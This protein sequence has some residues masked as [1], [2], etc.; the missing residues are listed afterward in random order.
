MM[1]GMGGMGG[2][3]GGMGGG[4]DPMQMMG[5]AAMA[6]QLAKQVKDLSDLGQKVT[7]RCLQGESKLTMQTALKHAE[8]PAWMQKSMI[9][10][11]PAAL[12]QMADAVTA[13]HE[14]NTLQFGQSTG[15][16]LRTVLLNEGGSVLPEK[17]PPKETYPNVT[18][19]FMQ[20]FFGKGMTATIKT[21]EAPNGMQIDLHKCVGRNVGLFESIWASVV[22]F[23]DNSN[24]PSTE[25]DKEQ[26]AT[27]MAYF[28]MQMPHIMQQCDL[29]PE[30][31]Q[32]LKD[33]A[34][35]M[36][37]GVSMQMHIPAPAQ[38]ETN[39]K[40]VTDMAQTVS[41]YQK[42]IQHP[43]SSLEFGQNLGKV[44]QSALETSMSQKYYV[45][46]EGNLRLRQ[47]TTRVPG[48]GSMLTP[49]LLVLVVVLLL[50]VVVAVKS[51][52]AL[53]GWKEHVCQMECH[54]ALQQNASDSYDVEAHEI[55]PILDEVH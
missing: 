7:S 52:R 45:D 32:A 15:T 18:G 22:K 23:Y 10:N 19:G 47:L 16:A 14:G 37:K 13:Y 36:G 39:T 34:A 8:S 5:G 48:A 33:A 28:A 12:G 53:A 24:K 11:G 51:R 49:A 54:E 2:M 29:S 17:L 46:P 40:A 3:P 41:G 26:Q 20:G 21:P 25:A 1:G 27:L 6:A 42:L 43:S 38:P 9:A 44:F 4:P 35:G 31:I 30:N 55:K 50:L